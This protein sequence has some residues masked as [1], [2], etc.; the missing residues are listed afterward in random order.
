MS[1]EKSTDIPRSPENCEQRRQITMLIALSD[2]QATARSL[3]FV[4][5]NWISNLDF[6][7][8][9]STS[10][11]RSRLPEL[12]VDSRILR[13]TTSSRNQDMACMGGKWEGKW[14]NV[15]RW[16]VC[17]QWYNTFDPL[18][19][20]VCGRANQSVPVLRQEVPYVDDVVDKSSDWAA[21]DS[22]KLLGSRSVGK[23]R[24]DV[25][26]TRVFGWRQNLGR[27]VDVI[28][29]TWLFTYKNNSNV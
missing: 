3:Q 12:K 25:K 11:T 7:S 24:Q 17:C 2:M 22:G 9:F 14:Q 16:V 15:T 21:I 29:R 19:A 26:H 13:N 18:T 27:Q 28:Y 6:G 4:I 23:M 8:Q 5:E 10:W 20:F 1:S